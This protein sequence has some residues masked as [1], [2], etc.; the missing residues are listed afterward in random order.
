MSRDLKEVRGLARG[1][2]L[3]AKREARANALRWAVRAAALEKPQGG[4]RDQGST[5][6]GEP[7][8]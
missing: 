3:Q 5:S 2:V 7:E 8:E 4:R 1:R 6:R